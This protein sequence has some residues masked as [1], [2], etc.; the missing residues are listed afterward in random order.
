MM[1]DGRGGGGWEVTARDCVGWS[2]IGR[3]GG[4]HH[5]GWPGTVPVMSHDTIQ[6]CSEVYDFNLG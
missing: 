1:E 3:D 6:I 2:G 4:G 5:G